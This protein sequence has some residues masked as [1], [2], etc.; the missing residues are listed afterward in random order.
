MYTD[1]CTLWREAAGEV[2]VESNVVNGMQKKKP[3]CVGRGACVG[4]CGYTADWAWLRSP[5]GLASGLG[6]GRQH[7]PYT[8]TRM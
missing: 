3:R 1:Y 6:R 7:S 8:K 4:D 2:L 5:L